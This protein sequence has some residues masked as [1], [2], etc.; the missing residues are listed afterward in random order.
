[1][2]SFQYEPKAKCFKLL[3]CSADSKALLMNIF[4]MF[5]YS[6]INITAE[7]FM[8]MLENGVVLCQLAQ[9]LQERMILASN[10]KV[11]GFLFL[12]L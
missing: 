6:G 4:C 7:N 5:N 11:L 12:L 3:A 1:M 10:G 2:Y 8:D 9:E